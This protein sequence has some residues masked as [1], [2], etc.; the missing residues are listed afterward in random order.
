MDM[1]YNRMYSVNPGYGKSRFSSTELRDILVSVVVLSLA[2]TIMYHDNNF[3]TG[4]LRAYGSGVMYAGLFGM[5]LA[6][7]TVSFLFHELGHKFAAQKAGLWS[8]YRMYPMG[9]MLALIM[10]L[11]GFLFAAPGAVCIAGNMSRETN[12]RVSIAGPMVNIMFAAA[13]LALCMVFNGSWLVVPFYLLA[14]LNAFLAVFNLLPIPPLD[15]SKV[16]SWNKG[17]WA[18]AILIAAAE[19]IALWMYVSPELYYIL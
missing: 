1:D 13:S 7:V 10:S 19:L 18:V 9:L 5:S 17:V 4:F 16:L 11:I 8:E 6:L 2:F 12:G 14:S 15:G 3:A